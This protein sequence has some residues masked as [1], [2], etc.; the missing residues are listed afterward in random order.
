MLKYQGY[1]GIVEYD[2][3]GRIFTGE[4]IGLRSVITF[5]GRTAD[6]I[7]ASFRE[8]ID[9][10]LEMCKEDGVAPEKPYSGR[11]NLRISPELHRKIAQR[12]AVERKSLNDWVSETLNNS[13]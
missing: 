6:E 11:F 3:D 7:E 8:S 4:V 12:A 5:Q 13:L 1:S 10:Y 9:V 2:S